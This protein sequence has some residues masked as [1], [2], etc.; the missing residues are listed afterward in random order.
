MPIAAHVHVTPGG[1]PV[2]I[3]GGIALLVVGVIVILA[4]PTL[5]KRVGL[6]P[7]QTEPPGPGQIWITR[8]VGAACSAFGLVL[9][10]L[11]IFVN[12]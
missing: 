1:G 6:S 8:I 3:G 7:D 10:F 2:L 12:S 4:A 5:Q 9:L 11:G